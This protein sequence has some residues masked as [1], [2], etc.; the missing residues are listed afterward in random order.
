MRVRSTTGPSSALFGGAVALTPHRCTYGRLHLGED[1]LC[2]VQPEK[3]HR[4]AILSQTRERRAYLQYRYRQSTAQ[5][6]GF[7]PIE[8][9]N[10][11]SCVCRRPRRTAYGGRLCGGR[12]GSFAGEDT[13]KG[14]LCKLVHVRVSCNTHW[15]RCAR[16]AVVS[17]KLHYRGHL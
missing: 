14:R 7:V 3:G 5:L 4:G 1:A 8:R 11:G 9:A 17:M 6:F 16:C 15:R 2:R 13:E 12:E 10:T